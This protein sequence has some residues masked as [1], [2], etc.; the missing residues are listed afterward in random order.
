MGIYRSTNAAYGARVQLPESMKWWDFI[1][2]RFQGRD[3]LPTR[4]GRYDDGDFFLFV[5]ETW[6]T[7]EPGE[8]VFI[9]PYQ[10]SAE[11]Y[12]TWDGL[13]VAMA[14]EMKVSIIGQPAWIFAPSES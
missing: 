3:V 6:K 12:L 10:A 4:E 5:K 9:G 7:P 13:L 1:D 11:P 8:P 2:E 14:E